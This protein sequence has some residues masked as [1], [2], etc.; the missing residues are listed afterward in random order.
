MKKRAEQTTAD[1]FDSMKKV[2]KTQKIVVGR[3]T[4]S[5]RVDPPNKGGDEP[6][7]RDVPDEVDGQKMS[8][9]QKRK[10]VYMGNGKKRKG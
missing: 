9:T 1:L 8:N 2:D 6:S 4:L 10:I 7:W 3:L 5:R